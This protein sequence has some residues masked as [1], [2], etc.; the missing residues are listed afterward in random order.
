MSR[1]NELNFYGFGDIWRYNSTQLNII[2]MNHEI[3][4]NSIKYPENIADIKIEGY[5]T[6]MQVIISCVTII[7]LINERINEEIEKGN[8]NIPKEK[9]D[10][11]VFGFMIDRFEEKDLDMDEEHRIMPKSQ[12]IRNALAHTC[13]YYTNSHGRSSPDSYNFVKVDI[14]K[15][16]NGECDVYVH[17]GDE[18]Y[19]MIDSD[20]IK[21]DISINELMTLTKNYYWYYKRIVAKNTNIDLNAKDNEY[22]SQIMETL[23]V[24]EK[25]KIDNY[26]D[27]YIGRESFE[28]MPIERKATIVD[29]V[30]EFII[31]KT[32]IP[33]F[34]FLRDFRNSLMIEDIDY[35]NEYE[36]ELKPF[37]YVS[38]VYTNAFYIFDYMREINHSSNYKDFFD[39]N[40]M[41]FL[42]ITPYFR[43]SKEKIYTMPNI[44]IYN[45]Q[46]S[47]YKIE[48][49]KLESIIKK[50]NLLD[51]SEYKTIVIDSEKKD[52]LIKSISKRIC[53]E[54]QKY[55]E[56][57]VI[58]VFQKIYSGKYDTNFFNDNQK[59]IYDLIIKTVKR[60]NN[61]K[62]I[63]YNI[64]D[65]VRAYLPDKEIKNYGN[66]MR[67]IR[68]AIAHGYYSFDYSNIH[69]DSNLKNMK[70]TLEDYDEIIN[71]LTQKK[72]K[73][74][75]FK[76]TI[77]CGKFQQ[78]MDNCA[79]HIEST[80][81]ESRE[82]EEQERR[83]K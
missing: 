66:I 78:I 58:E 19:I 16:A 8:I 56:E 74:L 80:I 62:D 13:Y 21:G 14:H 65:L 50:N 38:Q 25:E 11:A 59:N 18:V 35:Y 52:I 17:Y 34:I 57:D 12:K 82:Q 47:D 20:H 15:T 54:N 76:L 2:S 3:F 31:K 79:Q 4:S 41:N 72:E 22:I 70:I 64:E 55:R 45:K 33:D 24:E 60:F 5:F 30:Y 48:L 69:K 63:N 43:N 23:S 61:N 81:I 71:S 46:L 29:T 10:S 7:S 37:F 40:G 28:N 26:I 32:L 49:K 44:E 67:H 6:S 77:T 27:N 9:I 68:N 36:L 73:V 75:S 39:Y 53:E 51:R 83:R 42:N 1:L